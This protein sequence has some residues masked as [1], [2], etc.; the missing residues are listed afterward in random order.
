MKGSITLFQNLNIVLRQ[1]GIL[2]SGQNEDG[3]GS[4]R[5]NYF[6]ISIVMYICA[7]VSYFAFE[8]ETIGEHTDAFYMY[9]TEML[10]LFIMS[11]YIRKLL[12][13]LALIEKLETFFQ[14]SK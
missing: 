6:I 12:E 10:A 11:S 8:A 7:S 4:W 9:S 3:T 5:R 13:I 14:E 1:M 2:P